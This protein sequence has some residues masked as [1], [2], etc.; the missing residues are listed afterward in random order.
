MLSTLSPLP[1]ASFQAL[2]AALH[3]EST[4][5]PKSFTHTA[6]DCCRVTNVAVEGMK[7]VQMCFANAEKVLT[8][9]R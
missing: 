2:L 4:Q 3:Y 5:G 7:H 9:Q 8:F 1:L 6:I